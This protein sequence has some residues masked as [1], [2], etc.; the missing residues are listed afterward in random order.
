[1]TSEFRFR[2]L[3]PVG[4]SVDGTDIEIGASRQRALLAMLLSEANRV[5]HPTT[6]IEGIWGDA[7]PQ[8]PDAALQIVVSRLRSALGRASARLVSDR[9]GYRIVVEPDELDLE[10]AQQAFD[11]ARERFIKDDYDAAAAAA[12]MGLAC[13]SGDSL[14]DVRG[15]PF[16]ESAHREFRELRFSM[17]DFRNRAYLR[18]GRHV[19]I[20]ADIEGWIRSD[21]SRERTRATQMVALFRSGRRVEA[22]AAYEELRRYLEEELGIEPSTYIQEL[23]ARIEDEDPILLARR[24]GIVPRLPAWTSYDLPFVGRLREEL[25][26]FERLRELASGGTRMVLITGE[27]G[28]GKSRLVLEVARRAYDE[29][30]VL[31]VDGADALQPGIK[32]I[33]GALFDAATTMSDDEL[34]CCLGRWPGDVAELVPALR[35]RLPGL[36]AALDGGDDDARAG[37]A[38]DALVSWMAGMSQ[39]APVILILDD[40]HRA[41]PELLFFIGALVTA[42]EPHRVLVLATAR[43]AGSDFSSRLEQLVRRVGDHGFL[44]RIELRGLSLASVQ[45]L[46]TEL[47]A[48]DVDVAELVE[49]TQGHPGRLVERLREHLATRS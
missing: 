37:R 16:Y 38:R 28:I 48:S 30:I 19:Q 36:P 31:T 34:E 20:L 8:H 25:R 41:G 26:I 15:V 13:W 11:L 47:D 2:I 32:T 10:R 9:G 14:A 23:R 24:A 45:R 4:L 29:T 39:R 35:R 33:A 27:V 44:D 42:D 43:C 3:G 1:M 7:P 22:F 18:S 40:L 49:L 46:L 17:Y 12:S 21:P 5:V 6:L